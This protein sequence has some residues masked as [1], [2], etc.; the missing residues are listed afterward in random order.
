MKSLFFGISIVLAFSAVS[1]QETVNTGTG[2]VL[3]VSGTRF[4][5]PLVRQWIS[6]FTRQNPAVQIRLV[7]P[8]DSAAAHADVRISAAPLPPARQRAG[9]E[10]VSV[11]R[12][13]LLPVANS[14]SVYAQGKPLRVEELR[15][16]Y[17]D[18]G[19]GKA[20]EQAE[21]DGSAV[22]YNRLQKACAPVTFAAFY[23]ETFENIRGRG[24]A[25]DDQHLLK[26]VQ[27]DEKAVSFNNPGFIYDLQTRKPVEQISVI[28]IDLNGNGRLDHEEDFYQNLDQLIERLET[29]APADIPV[30]DVIFYYN[31]ELEGGKPWLK[32]WIGF[33][34]TGGQ[35]ALHAYGFL[36]PGRQSLAEQNE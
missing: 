28:P 35:S 12:Y 26:A 27:G 15:K 3:T 5:Y 13:A 36:Q 1:A 17:F 22:V 30:A 11:A 20:K 32:E 19:S 33:I 16:L 24:V 7:Q 34:Q 4:T 8:G 14:R 29:A 25:G 9:V 23:G 31:R 10:Y 6:D 21:A 2:K 18:D